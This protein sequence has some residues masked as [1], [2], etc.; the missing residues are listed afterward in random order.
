MD[1]AED[2]VAGVVAEASDTGAESEAEA[3][4]AQRDSAGEELEDS[5]DESVQG[6]AVLPPQPAGGGGGGG[7]G[8]GSGGKRKRRVT[9]GK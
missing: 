5:S 6:A 8:E 1:D 4:R 2:D 9:F 3:A 7:G